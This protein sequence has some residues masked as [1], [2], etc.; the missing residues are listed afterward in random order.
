MPYPKKATQPH[1]WGSYISSTLAIAV[2]LSSGSLVVVFAWISFLFIFTPNQINWINKL[3][4]EWM[5][6][7][8]GKIDHPQT[9][10]QIQLSLSQ[11]KLIAG[12]IIP[13]DGET[14]NSLLLP[15]FQSRPNC[16]NDCQSIVELRVY[17]QST[18]SPSTKKTEPYYLLVNQLPINGLERSEVTFSDQQS[19]SQ[20]ESKKSGS[21]VSLP[22]TEIKS[23]SVSAPTLGLWFYLQGTYPQ[24]E[25]N[26]SYGLIVYYNPEL[27]KLQQLL[28]WKSASGQP[29]RWRRQLTGRDSG[30]LIVDQTVGLEPRLQIYQVKSSNLVRDSLEME[31]IN[32]K[33]AAIADFDYENALLLARNGLWTS[34][35]SKM[36]SIQ[37]QYRSSLPD[38]AQAQID[39]ISLH[40]QLT[41]AQAEKTWASPSEQVLADLIDCQWEK[42]IDVFTA[43]SQNVREIAALLKTDQ[44][45]RLMSRIT[46]ASQLE[47]NNR[48]VL[49]WMTLILIVEQGEESG[50]SWLKKQPQISPQNLS[51]VQD[52]LAKLSNDMIEPHSS[53]IVGSVNQVNQVALNHHADWTTIDSK[54]DWTITKDQAWYYVEVSALND[55]RVW[56]KHPFTDLELPKAQLSEFFAEVL[57]ITTDRTIQLVVWL[58]NGEEQIT[59]ATIKAVQLKQGNLRLLV[60][61]SRITANQDT[62]HQPLALTNTTLEWIQPSPITIEQLYQQNPMWVEA[63]LPSIWYSLQ[64]SG[65]IP[66]GLIPTFPQMK[67][68]M[69]DWPV[70]SINLTGQN[71]PS[72]VIT[73]S[74]NAI[75]L[76]QQ[77]MSQPANEQQDLSHP[78]SLIISSSGQIIYTDFMQ[79]SQQK[80][81]A[82]AKLVNNELAL[83][84]ENGGRYDLERWSESNQRFE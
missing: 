44:G 3:L 45:H 9:L 81:I 53:Q 54:S 13:L 42:A 66:P 6:I 65:D 40:S 49:A 76:L 84:V 35:L 1:R 25:H 31:E 34:A 37:K 28:A 20:P 17:Q 38:T 27:K 62:S 78:R 64:K 46:L 12:A 83:L 67:Q 32:L 24:G 26:V 36:N 43:S 4:P 33:I 57:G 63:A 55:G 59:T 72:L 61:G 50:N 77:S 75:A 79:N 73:I 74:D 60:V 29:P 21:Q 41:Q 71:L 7:Y 22:L 69:Q 8:A 5:Q 51:Y 30:E 15:V 56:L 2:L 18:T 70:Q 52:I 16:A 23:F 39:L 68:K 47:P 82:I 19:I 11:Q 58:A 14:S 80:L 48:G 10:K